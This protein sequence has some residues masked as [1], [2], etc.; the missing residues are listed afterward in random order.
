MLNMM[1]AGKEEMFKGLNPFHLAD[2]K[3][4]RTKQQ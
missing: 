1:A 3:G 2:K 4:K